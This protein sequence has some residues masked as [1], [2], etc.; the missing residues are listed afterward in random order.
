VNN[1]PFQ[2]GLWQGLRAR[3]YFE[4]RQIA[5]ERR[6][7][8]DSAN[9]L[10]QL[11]N[12]LADLKMDVIVAA[13]TAAAQAA[14]DATST[15][16]IVV[17]SSGDPVKSGLVATLA[18]PGSNLTGTTSLIPEITGKRLEL[19]QQVVPDSRRVVVLVDSIDP[20][21]ADSQWEELQA[22]ASA[23]GAQLQRLDVKGLEDVNRAFASIPTPA[24]DSLISLLDPLGG[25]SPTPLVELAA[26]HRV[27]A[28]YPAREFVESGGLM[29]YGPN[30]R[31]Q[32]VRAAGYVDR[33]LRGARPAEL[34][35]QRPDRFELVIN[36]GTAEVLGI[37]MTESA[38]LLVDEVI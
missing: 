16:P 3:G 17:V 23:A 33:I 13:G 2:D 4:D 36:R 15:I 19:L 28:I 29:A 8:G 34:P 12:E 6:S 27:A 35:I 21:I 10:S 25:G 18:R 38:L 37:S 31:E 26:R 14:R 32:F 7:A 30:L 11:A 1:Q 9:R 24:A 20:T 22:G 5:V